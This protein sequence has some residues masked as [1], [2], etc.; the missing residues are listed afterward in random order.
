MRLSMVSHQNVCISIEQKRV[1]DA[2]H[3]VNEPYTGA[4]FLPRKFVL[5]FAGGKVASF[6]EA[7]A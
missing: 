1:T 6:A 5:R 3:T 4:V 2:A 7:A